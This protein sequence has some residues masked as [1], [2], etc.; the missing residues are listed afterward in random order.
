MLTTFQP[1]FPQLLR[2]NYEDT[3]TLVVIDVRHITLF[4]LH[5]SNNF[6]ETRPWNSE[7][8]NMQINICF[9][10][11]YKRVQIHPEKTHISN[12]SVSMN[13]N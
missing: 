9:D 4:A 7:Q 12:D 1:E 11:L 5:F 13:C 2:S 10:C 3:D 6:P 8:I